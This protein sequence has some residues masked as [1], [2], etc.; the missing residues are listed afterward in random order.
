[1]G[2]NGPCRGGNQDANQIRRSATPLGSLAPVA[3]ADGA[4]GAPLMTM[5]PPLWSQSATRAHAGTKSYFANG[6]PVSTCS[7]L[8]TPLMVPSASSALSFYSWRD[9]LEDTYDG[10][11]VEI[12]TNDG[13]S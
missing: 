12:S 8:S 6:N 7:Q 9:N 3:F 11:D 4:E 1:G 10:G 13:A 2:G 5:G